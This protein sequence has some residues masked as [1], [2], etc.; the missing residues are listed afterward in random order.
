[1]EE[2]ARP[3]LFAY[4]HKSGGLKDKFIAYLKFTPDG[5][6][7]GRGQDAIGCFYIVGNADIDIVGWSWV[8]SKT[9]VGQEVDNLQQW[10]EQAAET[11]EVAVGPGARLRSHVSH[12]SYWSNGREEEE[13]ADVTGGRAA[14]GRGG[15]EGDKRRSGG[16]Y[17]AG[18]STSSRS[19][20]SNTAPTILTSTTGPTILTSTTASSIPTPTTSH[21]MSETR[22]SSTQNTQQQL[23]LPPVPYHVP[24]RYGDRWT[25][26]GTYW[27]T[28]LNNGQGGYLYDDGQQNR[29]RPPQAADF[30]LEKGDEEM[31]LLE[32]GDTGIWGLGLWGVWETSSA[33]SHFDLQKGGVFRAVPIISELA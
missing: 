17:V 30:A 27:S 19:L 22:N 15:G 5:F 6:M 16:G 26:E 24:I 9:Y 25:E 29:P 31:G 4:Y 10:V 32:G 13:V 21:I 3:W 8:F 33:G 20:Q 23:S 14:G 2:N 12:L 18:S 7:R 28:S 11:V 1:M